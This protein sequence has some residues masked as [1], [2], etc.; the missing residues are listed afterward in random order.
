MINKMGL[1]KKL[2]NK[3]LPNKDRQ[4][5]SLIEMSVILLI[6]SVFIG[7]ILS[8]SNIIKSSSIT[9]ARSLTKTA[10]VND[11]NGLILWLDSVS[12]ESFDN[13]D[14]YDGDRVQ[15]WNDIKESYLKNYIATQSN[16][17]KQPTYKRSVVNRLPALYF[18][19]STFLQI[20][21]FTANA[22]LTIFVV[23]KFEDSN[24]F[25]EHSTNSNSNYG[26]MFQGGYNSMSPAI[27]SRSSSSQSGQ[28]SPPN[29]FSNNRPAIGVMRYDGSNISY[30]LNSNDFVNAA[31][32][33]AVNNITK[34]NLYI[35][36]R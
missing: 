32:S 16:S 8:F 23:G 29:W 6:L 12:V 7:A 4:A 13:E 19:N 1:K 17:S 11:I 14:I 28:P 10:I 33:D 31:D 27:V 24:F 15:N 2:T 35:G 20:A 18:G 34:S 3:S 5:F 22:Y 30:K 9:S 26:F 25:I 21:D 36:S